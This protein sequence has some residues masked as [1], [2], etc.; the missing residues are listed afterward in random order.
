MNFLSYFIIIWKLVL[1][2]IKWNSFSSSSSC[3]VRL[4]FKWNSMNSFIVNS[5]WLLLRHTNL[6]VD[7]MTDELSVCLFDCLTDWMT[8]CVCTVSIIIFIFIKILILLIYFSLSSPWILMID[9][10]KKH[11][12]CPCEL[13]RTFFLWNLLGF[14]FL[15]PIYVFF[16]RKVH[17]YWYFFSDFKI[18]FFV[19]F[20][21]S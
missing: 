18:D 21:T 10:W 14:K 17:L 15:Q 4:G 8:V 3:G 6:L 1:L 2:K 5:Y 20:V 12:V 11:N 13:N 16:F 9:L 19:L 7:W